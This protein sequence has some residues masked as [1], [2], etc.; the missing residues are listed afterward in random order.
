MGLL[1]LQSD[2]DL[3]SDKVL[4]VLGGLTIFYIVYTF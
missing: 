4:T 2:I 3:Q 1:D